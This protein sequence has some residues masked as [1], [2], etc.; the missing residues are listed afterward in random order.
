LAQD[1]ELVERSKWNTIFR[2]DIPLGIFFF[3]MR[4]L[5]FLLLEDTKTITRTKILKEQIFLP[6]P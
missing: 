6:T 5:L 4:V 3:C 2:L 1:L